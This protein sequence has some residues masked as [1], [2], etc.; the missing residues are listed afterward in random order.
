M[1]AA[2][3]TAYCPTELDADQ[4]GEVQILLSPKDEDDEDT[5]FLEWDEVPDGAP[6]RRTA[7]WG[8]AMG[9]QS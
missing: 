1:N 2:W 4:D 5:D 6:W 9:E 3:I 7:I 8:R